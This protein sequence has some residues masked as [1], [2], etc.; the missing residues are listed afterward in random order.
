MLTLPAATDP[1]ADKKV[2]MLE[3]PTPQDASIACEPV[4]KGYRLYFK[5]HMLTPVEDQESLIV[6]QSMYPMTSTF[7]RKVKEIKV[8][9]E[10]KDAQLGPVQEPKGGEESRLEDKLETGVDAEN[11]E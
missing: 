7:H 3:N 2:V 8:P 10:I 5:S 4:A 11:D 1:K 6:T 9:D